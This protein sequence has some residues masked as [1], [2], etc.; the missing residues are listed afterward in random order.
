MPIKAKNPITKPAET[1][2]NV[3]LQRLEV[4]APIGGTTSTATIQITYYSDAGTAGPSKTIYIDQV[5]EKIKSGDHKLAAAYT[6]IM[7]VVAEL[8][9]Q[10]NG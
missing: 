4:E 8:E 2:D 5:L 6:A 9:G 10:E 7:A 1:F 3:W